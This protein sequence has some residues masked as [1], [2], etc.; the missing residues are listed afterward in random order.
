METSIRIAVL[1]LL[2]LT[3]YLQQAV[4]ARP[5]PSDNS[6]TIPVSSRDRVYASDQTSNSVSVIDPSTNKLL[7]VIQLGGK[8]SD[9][10]SAVYRGQSLVHGMGFSPDH[11]TLAIVCVGSNALV[12]IDTNTSKVKSIT[13]VGRAPHEAM[14]TPNGK[15]VWVAVRGEDFIQVL[16]GNTYQ[17]TRQVKVPNGPG[18][19]IF[20]PDGKYAYICS[21]FTPETVVVDTSTYNIV[22]R[23]KQASVFCPNIAVTPDGKQVWF[24]LKDSGKVQVF[25]ALP[26]FQI[27]ALLETG[28]I[29]NHVNHARTPAGQ[30]L[31]YVTVGG[32]NLVKVFT[33]DAT[34][35]LLKSIAT[36]ANP[37]GL[38]PSG[39]GSRVYV[40]LQLGNAVVAIDTSRNTVLETIDVGGQAPM[41]LMY[42]PEAVQPGSTNSTA[43]L[44]P[45]AAAQQAASAL[46]FQLV[47][48]PQQQN[49]SS[50]NSSAGSVL[51]SVVVN[52][53]G[54][55]DSLEAAV[56]ALKPGQQYVL[57][58]ASNR[59]G[60]G[61][62][63]EPVAK[64]V[65]GADGA[66]SVAVL[67]PFKDM[68]MGVGSSSSNGAAA[69]A[70][71]GKQQRFIVVA[72]VEG[73]EGGK[74]KPAIQVQQIAV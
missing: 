65:G 50:S 74:L 7:G 57:A 15:E 17:P 30:Q 10:L 23:V 36:G 59:D 16:D 67:G 48:A 38:W 25:N 35:K 6:A 41:A 55:I 5:G 19:T 13:Y 49:S 20:A 4:A 14:W 63:V 1:S 18:M 9:S 53:Q 73:G 43:N 26:P 31:A 3:V 52:S 37:H 46:H 2:V 71:Q 44:V 34:P 61:E 11:K 72:P 47:A 29:T 24:T 58:L 56:T 32:L 45:A 69:G 12:F 70:G 66:A 42:V 27:T 54:L 39:D 8:L 64:F 62:G 22:G 40:G 60:S 68:L 51:S 21:S 28:P 33:T